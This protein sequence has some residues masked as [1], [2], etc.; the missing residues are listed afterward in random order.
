VSAAIRD[1]V[2]AAQAIDV[3]NDVASD[4]AGSVVRARFDEACNLGTSPRGRAMKQSRFARGK[5]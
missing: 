3:G 1:R 4:L 2:H 5:M